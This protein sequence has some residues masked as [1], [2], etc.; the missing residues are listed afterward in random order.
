MEPTENRRLWTIE[1]SP[2]LSPNLSGLISPGALSLSMS[3]SVESVEGRG[4]K[5]EKEGKKRRKR[6]GS[7]NS[8]TVRKK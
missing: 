7:M 8:K 1:S 4:I 3:I 5:L 6:R 2:I